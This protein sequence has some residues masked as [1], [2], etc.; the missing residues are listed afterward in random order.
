M[1]EVAETMFIAAAAAAAESTNDSTSSTQAATQR[2]PLRT[3]VRC[4]SEPT[5]CGGANDAL[6]PTTGG[7]VAECGRDSPLHNCFTK[8]RLSTSVMTS[9]S[10]LY[11]AAVKTT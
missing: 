6:R 2:R 5:A 3:H 10:A 11:G 8:V 7:D 9:V 1:S 4:I